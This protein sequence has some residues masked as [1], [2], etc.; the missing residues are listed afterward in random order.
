MKLKIL[1]LPAFIIL[2]LVLAIGYIKPNLDAITDKQTEIT[3]QKDALSRV[4]SVKSNIGTISEVLSRRRETADFIERYYPKSLDEERVVDMFNYLAQQSGASVVDVNVKQN[5]KVVTVVENAVPV[6]GAAVDTSIAVEAPRE[7]PDSYEV[8]ISVLGE[9]QSIK[10]FFN[11]V[12]QVDRLHVTKE[13][14]IIHRKEDEL[15]K[16]ADGET[17]EAAP[18]KVLLGTIKADFPYIKEKRVANA[19]NIPIFQASEFDFTEADKLVE[20]VKNPLPPLEVGGAG[21]VNP[22][23]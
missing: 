3:V 14:S 21:R 23:E 11:R 19:L 1:V 9:Y 17:M 18:K 6:D 7:M 15:V 2:E 10:D 5:E 22:F 4:D 16:S 12:Y 8:E 13:F 20:F